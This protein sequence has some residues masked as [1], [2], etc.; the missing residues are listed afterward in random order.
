MM[1]EEAFLKIMLYLM[2]MVFGGFGLVV[3]LIALGVHP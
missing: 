2:I 3:I 1:L